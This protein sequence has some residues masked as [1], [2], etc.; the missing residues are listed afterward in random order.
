MD[1]TN[2]NVNV[3]APILTEGGLYHFNLSLFTLDYANTLID[4]T[5]PPKFDSYLSVGDVSNQDV[6]YQN[7]PYNTTLI[8][9]YDKTSDFKFDES[10]KQ[11]SWKMPF[12]WDV[13][14][15]K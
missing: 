14:R 11:F 13:N 5:S 10:T 7:N 6:T 1:V 9:Y 15:F 3:I 2:D 12:D 8:S 4:Q